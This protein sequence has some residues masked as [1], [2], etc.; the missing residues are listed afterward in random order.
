M[1]AIEELGDEDVGICPVCQKTAETKYQILSNFM[2]KFFQKFHKGIRVYLT[3]K[4]LF[5]I[6]LINLLL[7]YL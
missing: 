4:S 5:R 3:F 1:G 2:I 7:W 6:S